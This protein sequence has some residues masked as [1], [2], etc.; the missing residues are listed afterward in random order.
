MIIGIGIDLAQVSK[1]AN[2]LQSA[3]F[4]RKTFSEAELADSALAKNGAE[5]L[6]GKFAAKEAFM[7]AAGRGIRQGLWFSQIEVLHRESGQ[8]YIQVS[9]EAERALQDLRVACIHVSISHAGG[10]ATAVVILEG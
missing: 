10:M 9:G 6:A 1:L 8:P 4:L 2:S 3:A 5:R 7:K